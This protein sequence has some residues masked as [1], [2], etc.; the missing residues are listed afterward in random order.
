MTTYSFEPHADD[1]QPRSRIMVIGRE[2]FG[3]AVKKQRG[4]WGVVFHRHNPTV[5]GYTAADQDVYAAGANDSSF[6]LR[7]MLERQ[8]M[9]DEEQE[10]FITFELMA[11]V[12]NYEKE[13]VMK[14]ARQSAA[15]SLI[16]A[17][18]EMVD[19]AKKQL[20]DIQC[21]DGFSQPQFDCI[22]S[23]HSAMEKVTTDLDLV[24]DPD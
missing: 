19:S 10:Q 20:F 6:I 23:A 15:D 13:Y 4:D 1:N 12:M 17:L 22:K 21:T 9:G 16:T 8:Q 7:A 3:Y 2:W 24:V 11:A 14:V 5:G 18:E